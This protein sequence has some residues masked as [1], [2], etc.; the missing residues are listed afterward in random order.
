MNIAL[1]ATILVVIF[2]FIDANSAYAYLDAGTGSMI[3]Q[4]LLGGLAGAAVILKVFWKRILA[5]F[6][7]REKTEEKAKT[8][9][10]SHDS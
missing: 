3:I 4:I 2:T 7:K 1:K 5:I 6:G 10:V 8:K 9:T